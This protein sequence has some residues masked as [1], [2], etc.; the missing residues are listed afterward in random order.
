MISNLE[1]LHILQDII[2][3]ID[4][5]VRLLSEVGANISPQRDLGEAPKKFLG[6]RP[7]LRLQIYIPTYVQMLKFYIVFQQ[8]KVGPAKPLSSHFNH[9][10]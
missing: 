2:S 3:S 10:K 4:P 6:T 5:A 8:L 7:L 9:A 1:R